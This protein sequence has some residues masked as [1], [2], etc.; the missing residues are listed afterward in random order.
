MTQT[1]NRIKLTSDFK[2]LTSYYS[3]THK[4]I[5]QSF[6]TLQKNH[7]LGRDDFFFRYLQVRHYLNKNIK[8]MLRKD[9]SEFIEVFLSSN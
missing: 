8:E 7:G 1:L 4:G 6:E 5:F 2:G 9:E 3:F